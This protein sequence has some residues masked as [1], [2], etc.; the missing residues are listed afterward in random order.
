MS[1]RSESRA[2]EPALSNA[3]EGAEGGQARSFEAG[4]SRWRSR[5][6]AFPGPARGR[7]QGTSP[8]VAR[9]DSAAVDRTLIGEDSAGLLRATSQPAALTNLAALGSE[10]H[11]TRGGIVAVKC[12][13]MTDAELA[14]HHEARRIDIRVLSLVVLTE[15]GESGLLLVGRNAGDRYARR[16]GQGIEEVDGGLPFFVA[17][18]QIV[19]CVKCDSGEF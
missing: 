8:P 16:G 12:Q 6:A 4:S 2:L 14:H 17:M 9:S 11:E 5:R 18:L 3:R 7:P 13:R 1:T 10:L 19:C 15:P